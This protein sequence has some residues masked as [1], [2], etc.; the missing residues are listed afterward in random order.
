MLAQ[1]FRFLGDQ[2]GPPPFSRCG[3]SP[4]LLHDLPKSTLLVS[5]RT[6]YTSFLTP[7][8][9]CAPHR[10]SEWNKPRAYSYKVTVDN[11]LKTEHL[12]DILQIIVHHMSKCSVE[13][14]LYLT[15]R[16]QAEILI[17]HSESLRLLVLIPVTENIILDLNL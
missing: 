3:I 14:F 16:L 6:S 5:R 8:P 11:Y 10:T 1:E 15:W 13:D 12:S 9:G 17:F 2:S 4:E 7:K